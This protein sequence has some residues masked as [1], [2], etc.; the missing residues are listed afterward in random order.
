MTTAEI[1][2]IVAAALALGVW[3]TWLRANRLD[4]LHRKVVST[5][6][7]LDTQLVRRAAVAAELATSGCLDP[8][9][10]VLLGQGA[11][12]ALEVDDWEGPDRAREE[13]ESSLS[14]ILRAALDDPEE[15]EALRADLVG[16]RLLEDLS[17][18]WYRV[19]LARR[20]HNESVAQTQRVRRKALV[21][22]FRLAGHAEMPQTIEIDDAWPGAVPRPGSVT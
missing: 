6:A 22:L 4:R 7:T 16:S 14:A 15:V 21:R 8:V 20:F 12:E 3:L 13:I 17:R 19:Q 9:S 18:A 10:S 5:R 2:L 1:W 11:F